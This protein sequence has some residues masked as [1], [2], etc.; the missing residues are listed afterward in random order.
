MPEKRRLQRRSGDGIAIPH[1]KSDGVKEPSLAAIT[2]PGGV[3]YGA[4][5]GNPSNLLFMIAA[6]NDGDVHLEVLSRLMTI[7]MD[8]DF[9]QK[10][11]SAKTKE[12]FIAVIDAKENERYPDEAKAEEKAKTGYRILA[13]TA[14]PTGI[15]HTYMAAEA[16]ERAAEKLGYSIK[17]ETN[18]SGGAKNVLTK[19]EIEAADGIIIAADKSVDMARFDGKR[20]ISTKVS[21]GIKK[22]EELI[23][24]IINGDAGIYKHS[25]EIA[26]SE[27]SEKESFGRQ[28]L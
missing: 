16:L 26:K 6:P 19:E 21:D 27:S 23:Q 18:G 13:V 15:A 4:L 25:G 14:C 28:D 20:L 2:V 5:D 3:D 17:V 7:L 24:K 8:A 11:L 9:R 1:A 12:D 10:L 22:P